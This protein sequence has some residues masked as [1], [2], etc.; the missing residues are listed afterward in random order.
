MIKVAEES[1]EPPT[2]EVLNLRRQG[3]GNE[4]IVKS[5][6]GKK[7][8]SQQISDAINQ[9]SI[10]ESVAGFE[11]PE[12]PSPGEAQPSMF[13]PAVTETMMPPQGMATPTP[14]TRGRETIEVIQE[15]TESIINEK[16]EDLMS[17]LGNITLW[18]EK[19]QTD[20]RSIKQEIVRVEERF[21]NLQRAILGKVTDYDKHILDMGSEVR[22]LEKVMQKII[23]PLTQNIKDLSKITEELK[24]RKTK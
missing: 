24:S 18:K 13:Q 21:E 20:I 6:Q 3:I 5:L 7:Y 10:K 14:V 9:V 22:A 15:L 17:S 12:A 19:I 23:E 8:S 2:E 16:W 11:V 1:E 4:N